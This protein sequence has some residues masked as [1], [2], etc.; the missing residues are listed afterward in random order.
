[1]NTLLQVRELKVR[2][3]GGEAPPNEA[4]HGVSFDIGAGEVVGLMGE[5]GCGKSSI[6]LALL[7]LLDKH[8]A[9][10][11]GSILFRSQQL[12]SLNER[13]FEKIR[14]TAISIVFQEPGIALSPVM[15]AGEQVTEVIHAHRGW[16][17]KRCRAEAKMMLA[18]VGLEDTRRIFAAYPHQLSGGQRQRVTLAQ[19]LACEPELVVAD[20]PTASLDARSQAGF[21]ELLR[22]LKA[23]S[24]ISILL[25]SH[26]PEIQASLADR[27]LVMRNGIIIESGNFNEVYQHPGQPYTRLLFG[28]RSRS[29]SRANDGGAADDLL[30]EQTVR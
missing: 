2:Y 1:M 8:K 19:A 11:S 24:R 17:W 14:G 7:G 27:L 3:R 21:I 20:E 13:Q 4:V 9:D 23:Q 28:R 25:I 5:S 12:V 15:R 29:F 18:R 16:S 26:T 10:V 30:Q 6:S 22:E